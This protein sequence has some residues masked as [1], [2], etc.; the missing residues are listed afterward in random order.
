MQH[1]QARS[2]INAH[3]GGSRGQQASAGR[4]AASTALLLQRSAGNRAVSRLAVQGRVLQ[5]RAPEPDQVAS[6]IGGSNPGAA[7]AEKKLK[8]LLKRMIAELG[9]VTAEAM[10]R[11]SARN[12]QVAW[13]DVLDEQVSLSEDQR[14]LLA[15]LIRDLEAAH[16]AT[17][18]G[19]RL[20]IYPR[21][22]V[23]ASH[24]A[25]GSPEAANLAQLV[26][27]ATATMRA[28]ADGQHDAHL[29][30]VFGA[31]A[32]RAKKTYALA[33]DALT[34]LHGVNTNPPDPDA[35]IKGI[36]IDRRDDLVLSTS[37][38]LTSPTRMILQPAVVADVSLENVVTIIHESTHAIDQEAFHT[39]DRAYVDI[40]VNSP[41]LTMAEADRVK[42]A[43]Y[44]EE[45]A[46]QALGL[47]GP[48]AFT[49]HEGGSN[50]RNA[51]AKAQ[52]AAGKIVNDAWTVALNVAGTL[53]NYA[54]LQQSDRYQNTSLEYRIK[55]G[56]QL[57]NLS[58]VVGLT[59]HRRMPA[60][61][62][63]PPITDL[64][65]ALAEDRAA[66]LAKL[67][68]RV[69]TIE[70]V[71]DRRWY[72]RW[73]STTEYLAGKILE[74]LVVNQ[75]VS[76]ARKDPKREMGMIL[77]LASVYDRDRVTSLMENVPEEL[78]RHKGPLRQ[79]RAA[80]AEEEA[81]KAI[82]SGY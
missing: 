56:R 16:V 71:D 45:A 22:S 62:E 5:R 40:R 70:V 18:R 67:V 60:N 36:L 43:A 37:K 10:R 50:E 35:K 69:K 3:A 23:E 55:F 42:C 66:R 21:P 57:S 13:D 7:A 31:Q 46:R 1:E 24:P 73:S 29:N 49:R 54:R 6:I 15:D 76:G 77:A 38:G 11:F 2:S 14:G 61:G 64:D 47:R 80:E 28:L 59:I 52:E 58:K 4:D 82:F 68:S 19:R 39:D 33:A 26:A 30:A 51:L 53:L 44:Y 41:F 12:P 32:A 48:L 65:L 81:T 74:E 72:E 34:D 79:D 25:A 17:G 9:P 63:A 75:R 8:R 20:L 27:R 78:Y